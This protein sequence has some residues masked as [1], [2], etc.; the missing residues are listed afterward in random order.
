MFYCIYIFLAY[1]GYFYALDLISRTF[2]TCNGLP[3]PNISYLDQLIIVALYGMLTKVKKKTHYCLWYTWIVAHGS[4]YVVHDSCL[5]GT[6]LQ[7][8]DA[9]AHYV[10]GV[11]WDPLGK[12]ASSLSSD[13]TCRI[14]MNKPHKS[15]GT[16]KVNYVC[17]QVI[18][19]ADQPLFKNSQVS[20]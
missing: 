11:A 4:W 8:L 7:T 18:S 19:K 17:Q 9:H 16:E 2:W 20:I 12:Y 13:R 10:Q 14:Y 6:N 3:M 15:K 1:K 5:P